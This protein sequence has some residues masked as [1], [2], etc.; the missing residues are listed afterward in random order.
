MVAAGARPRHV[1]VGAVGPHPGTAAGTPADA[2]P[3]PAPADAR[4]TG[5]SAQAAYALV[6]RALDVDPAARRQRRG[7]GLELVGGLRRAHHDRQAAAGQRPAPRGRASPGIWIQIGLQLPHRVDG[8]ARSTSAG[9]SFAGVPGVVIGH[10]ADIAWGFTN[11]GPDVSDFYLERVTGDT[12]L[13]DGA[14]ACRSTIRTRR[15][16]RWPAVADRRSPCAAP[17]TGRC[18]PTSSTGCRD[19][20]SRAPTGQ[21]GDENESYAVS[22]AWTGAAAGTRPPT[23][24]STS[25][26][27]TDFD[28]FREAA[29]TFAVPAQNLVYADTAGPHRLPGARAGADAAPGSSGAPRPGTGRP[30]AGTRRTT[31]RASSP[32]AEMPWALDPADGFIVTANQAVTRERDPVPDHGVGLRL[33]PQRIRDAARARPPKVDAGGHGRR[34]SSTPGA[35]VRPRPWSRPLLARST[36]GRRRFTREA[37]RAAARLGLHHAGRRRESGAAAA[38]YNAVWRNL[39]GCTFDD[40]LPTDLQADGGAVA[41]GR[42]RVLLTK[43]RAAV[44]GQQATPGVTEG[45]DE[46]L[47]QALVAARLELTRELGK[48]PGEWQWGKLHQ[49]D[50]PAPGARRRHGAGRGALAVQRGSVSSMPRRLVD[51][52]RQRL[53]RQ[54]DGVCGSSRRAPSMRMVVDLSDLDA[55][56]WVNQTGGSGHAVRRPL[57]RPDRRLGQGEPYAVAVHRGAVGDADPDVL[58]L[59]PEGSTSTRLSPRSMTPASAVMTASD[60][61]VVRSRG[62]RLGVEQLAG[63]QQATTGAPGRR[64]AAPGRSSPRPGPIRVPV[65]STARPGASTTSAAAIASVPEAAPVR[66][67]RRPCQSRSKSGSVIGTRDPY[68]VCRQGRVERLPWAARRHGDS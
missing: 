50:A 60:R 61:P 40:E 52:R 24:S 11:L 41:A 56:T 47:R 35:Q 16:S 2:A 38:Y 46:I 10:N 64:G 5:P 32:F 1:V 25:T 22:L 31:G 37:Q 23:P 55:S 45:K 67:R 18:C 15:S 44:V 36:V 39:L 63:V 28:Y 53:E 58:T 26:R 34:S 48:D 19:A 68:A 12:Y 66:G 33:P 20:G 7:R 59:R 30:R 49:L 4:V 14:L 51:R 62:R 13:R 65:R 29:R 21:E 3:A 54:R 27:A 9:F 17:C 43:P 42:A 6:H 8:A 57:R